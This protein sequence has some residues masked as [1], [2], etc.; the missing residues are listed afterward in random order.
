M[1]GTKRASGGCCSFISGCFLPLSSFFFAHRYRYEPL[2]F[3]T[4]GRPVCH[5]NLLIFYFVL[6]VHNDESPPLLHVL[7]RLLRVRSSLL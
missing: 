7:F 4:S 1:G 3:F 6:C 2:C 5:Q